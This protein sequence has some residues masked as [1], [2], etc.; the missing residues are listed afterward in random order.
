VLPAPAA[1]E[2]TLAEGFLEVRMIMA[3]ADRCEVLLTAASAP[4]VDLPA[5]SGS[6]GTAKP[7]GEA[8]SRNPS[9][10]CVKL[11]VQILN[12]DR[13]STA[14]LHLSF[15]GHKAE[16]AGGRALVLDGRGWMPGINMLAFRRNTSSFFNAKIVRAWE[17]TRLFYFLGAGA[18]CVARGDRDTV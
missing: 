10:A 11:K 16:T 1:F 17:N 5:G 7:A 9:L 13:A 12:H 14:V 2:S 3:L 18:G 8:A 15:E 6:A 4:A